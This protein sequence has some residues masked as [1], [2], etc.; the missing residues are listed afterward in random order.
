VASERDIFEQPITNY[1]SDNSYFLFFI[2]FLIIIGAITWRLTHCRTIERRY[3]STE[4]KRQVLKDQNYKCVICK[5]NI[6]VWDYDHEN[7]DRSNNK[8]SNCQ[9]L[10]PNC[11]AKKTRGLLMIKKQSNSKSPLFFI[12]SVIILFIVFIYFSNT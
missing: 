1:T 3:F 12:F 5:R 8:K 2:L 9:A 7:G 10:C 6:G 4:V 11:H